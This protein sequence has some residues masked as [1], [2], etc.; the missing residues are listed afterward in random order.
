MK[1]T[2]KSRANSIRSG[3]FCKFFVMYIKNFFEYNRQNGKK[4]YNIFRKEFI[5]M[6][7]KNTEKTI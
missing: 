3:F 4:V 7:M 5:V 2:Q 1:K 6:A